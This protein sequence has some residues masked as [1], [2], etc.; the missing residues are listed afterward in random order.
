MASYSVPAIKRLQ[1]GK[2]LRAWRERAGLTL[3]QASADLDLSTSTLS[4]MKKGQNRIEGVAADSCPA[5]E[6]E[7]VS[8]ATSR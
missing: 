1:L 2:E 7:A 3:E 8:V 5:L 6:V 4:R